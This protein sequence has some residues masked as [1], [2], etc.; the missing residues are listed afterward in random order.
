[1]HT[2]LSISQPCLDLITQLATYKHHLQTELFSLSFLV[3][4]VVVDS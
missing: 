2:M 4:L 3:F 1:M